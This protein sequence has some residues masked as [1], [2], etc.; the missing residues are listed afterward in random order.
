LLLK[1]TGGISGVFFGVFEKN[2]TII[3]SAKK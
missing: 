1:K 2:E 3:Q